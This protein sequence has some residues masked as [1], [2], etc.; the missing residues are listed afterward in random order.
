M[1]RTVAMTHAA[2]DHICHRFRATVRVI[3]KTGQIVIRVVAAKRVQHQEQIEP[4][5]QIAR[6]HAGELHT[7]AVRGGTACDDV[8][9][10]AGT[11]HLW[12]HEG[13]H[14]VLLKLGICHTPNVG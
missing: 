11:L 8:L 5:L 13:F 12:L 2:R 1:A 14:V 6:Q 7:R 9:D 3:G 4:A 10:E